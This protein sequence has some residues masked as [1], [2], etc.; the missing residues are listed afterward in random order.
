MGIALA[1]GFPPSSGLIAAIIGGLVTS[2]MGGARFTIKGPAAGLIV[3]VIGAVHDLADPSDPMS[4]FKRAAAIVVVSG[5]IQLVLGICRCGLLAELM[6]ISVVHGML[7]AIGLIII[8]KQFPIVCGVTPE[9]KTPSQL[10]LEI[11]HEFITSNPEILMIGVFAFIT[12]QLYPRIKIAA[13][14]KIP[15]VLFV[16]IGSILL[17]T[18]LHLGDPHSY[19]LLGK[20]YNVGPNYLVHLPQSLSSVVFMPD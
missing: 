6:P 9:G 17:G 7:A 15:A 12:M 10:L 13:F 20:S 11:P 18:Y 16:M 2:F 5:A 3:I 19:E 4:G 8:G 14:K 1:S